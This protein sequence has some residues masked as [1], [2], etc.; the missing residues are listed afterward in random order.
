MIV[1]MKI[2]FG[3]IKIKQLSGKRFNRSR[4]MCHRSEG[5]IGIAKYVLQNTYQITEHQSQ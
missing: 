2:Q 3:D 4:N 1:S 5:T